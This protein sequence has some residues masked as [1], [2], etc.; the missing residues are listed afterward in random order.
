VKRLRNQTGPSALSC[1]S[2]SGPA[3]PRW[4]LQ[5]GFS[6]SRRGTKGGR[7][8]EVI[9]SQPS[10]SL[11]VFDDTPQRCRKT[12]SHRITIHEHLQ[13]RVIA[14]PHHCAGF[15][16]NTGHLLLALLCQFDTLADPENR[17][18]QAIRP[19]PLRLPLCLKA[20]GATIMQSA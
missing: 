8:Q 18:A 7:I 5:A 12:S 1:S 13:R 3:L 20:E 16:A 19:S 2:R 15:G 14:E 11:V 17:C 10:G 6:A 9:F 4:R